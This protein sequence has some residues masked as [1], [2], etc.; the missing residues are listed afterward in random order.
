MTIRRI[1]SNDVENFT[2]ETHPPRFYSSGSTASSTP[3]ITGSV[4]VFP[5]RSDI[6]KEV[7]PLSAFSSSLFSDQNLEQ[8]IIQAKTMAEASSSNTNQI[9][10]YLSGVFAQQISARKQQT[11]EIYR[12]TPPFRLNKYTMAKLVTIN[13]LMPYYRTTQPTNHF[14]IT[15]YNCFNFF[16][17]SAVPTQS[18]VLYPNAQGASS[19]MYGNYT[20][21]GAWS[22]DFWINPKYTTDTEVNSFKAGTVLHLSGVFAVSLV[23]GSSRDING[24]PNGYRLLVQLSSSAGTVPSLATTSSLTFYS[25]DNSLTRNNWHHVTIRHGGPAPLYNQGTGSIFVDS[26]LDTE[27]ILTTSIASTRTSGGYGVTDG[28]CVLA[29]GNFYEGVNSGTSGM[30]RFFSGDVAARDGISELNSVAGVDYPA[31]FSFNHPLSAEIHDIK[32]FN[33]YLSVQEISGYQSSG[34]SSFSN[35]LFYVPPFFTVESPTR[36][37]VGSSGGVMVTP[38]QTQDITTRDPFNVTMSFAVGGMEMNLENFGKEFVRNLFPRWLSL[39]GSVLDTTAN[40]LTANQF[41]FATGSNRRRQYT[42]LPCDNGQFYPN[43]SFFLSTG[44][45][46]KFKNDLGNTNYGFISLRDQ[47]PLRTK[48]FGITSDSGSIIDGMLGSTPD[49]LS[50]SYSDGLAVLH[51]TRDNTS[52]QVVFFD[53]S[54]LFFGNRIK[55]GTVVLRD[56]SLS[57]SG[58]KLSVTL[59]D[60]GNGNLY[61]ADAASANATWASVGNVFYNEGI[62]L[63]KSPQYYFLGEEAWN[64]NFSGEQN[65]HVLKFN[66][67]LPPLLA[68]SSSNPSYVT[69]SLN[70]LDTLANESDEQYVWLSGLYLHDDNL[71]VISKTN[72]AQPIIKRTGDKLMFAVKTSF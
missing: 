42:I 47:V 10:S 37:F 2:L 14:A 32:I 16:T 21:T 40:I 70:P 49:N 43:F 6:E 9:E 25:S 3:G 72:F 62:I 26:V 67:L 50:G 7:Q 34:P 60:D 31:S 58:G 13:D 20:P 56:Q 69:S 8:L 24:F 35:L 41:L 1:T 33:K 27:F 63:V 18:V 53:I 11:V 28:P 65:I 64:I 59:R 17:S 5:R 29:V 71:N 15:N 66:L 23:T 30:S 22:I 45:S 38:F 46:D 55:P 4:Y 39:T 48:T 57:G 61:R 12:F 19:A 52:N 51:R 68:T 54:N 36:S 44:S